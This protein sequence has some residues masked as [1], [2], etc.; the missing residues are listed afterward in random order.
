MGE[1]FVAHRQ[2][3]T[4]EMVRM[5][6][7]REEKRLAMR[8]GVKGGLEGARRYE[9]NRFKKEKQRLMRGLDRMKSLKAR[10]RYSDNLLPDILTVNGKE[11]HNAIGDQKGLGNDEKGPIGEEMHVENDAK[12]YDRTKALIGYYALDTPRRDSDQNNQLPE[13]G[14]SSG[15]LPETEPTDLDSK[16]PQHS[17]PEKSTECTTVAPQGDTNSWSNMSSCT[18][19][20]SKTRHKKSKI[21]RMHERSTAEFKRAE[22]R[23][24]TF[25]EAL[26]DGEKWELFSMLNSTLHRK[27]RGDKPPNMSPN[28]Q[29]RIEALQRKSSVP[30]NEINIEAIK[31]HI[32]KRLSL[33]Q[34]NQ[35]SS[36]SPPYRSSPRSNGPRKPVIAV[37]TPTESVQPVGP[38]PELPLIQEHKHDR[39]RRWNNQQQTI[40]EAEEPTE[41]NLHGDHKP[42][43]RRR[44]SHRGKLGTIQEVEQQVLH[45][46]N[47]DHGDWSKRPPPSHGVFIDNFDGQVLYDPEIFNPDGSFRAK[48]LVPEF[49]QSL[50]VAQKARY[51]RYGKDDIP[52]H[53]KD[54]SLDEIFGKSEAN[55]EIYQ[56]NEKEGE[57]TEHLC[58]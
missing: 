35:G 15:S 16:S 27:E 33:G 39:V 5:M 24:Y 54:L 20:R 29:K 56:L 48:H 30:L 46:Q 42:R 7:E 49:A 19:P 52:E 44:M 12:T 47:G 17:N 11:E 40:P 53:E 50:A 22:E 21:E 28:E 3:R 14:H 8:L 2:Q 55:D 10:P 38:R 36:S 9:L 23:M 31:E 1:D 25:M 6:N 41:E 34:E 37:N 58:S 51:I 13:L 4:V 18:S 57:A 32:A 26:D 43:P 45:Q